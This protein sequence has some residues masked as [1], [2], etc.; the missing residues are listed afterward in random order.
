M[1]YD[2]IFITFAEMNLNW[3]YFLFPTIVRKSG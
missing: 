2:I 3:T 1:H